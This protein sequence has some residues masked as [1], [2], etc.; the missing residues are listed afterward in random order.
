MDKKSVLSQV[1][2]VRMMPIVGEWTGMQPESQP[3]HAH[4]T[5]A[6]AILLTTIFSFKR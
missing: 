2:S 4:S 5:T 6:A 3:T 1:T